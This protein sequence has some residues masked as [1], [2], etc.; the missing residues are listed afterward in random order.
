MTSQA[1]KKTN[2][3]GGGEA[4]KTACEKM[5]KGYDF[6]LAVNN[7]WTTPDSVIKVLDDLCD[8]WVFQQEEGTNG[9]VHWQGRVIFKVKRRLSTLTGKSNPFGIAHWSITGGKTFTA[10]NFNYV[11]TENKKGKVLDGPWSNKEN[12]ITVRREDKFMQN[13]VLFPWQ[14]KLVN[15][16]EVYDGRC[17]DVIYDGEGNTGKTAMIDYL[18][19]NKLASPIQPYSEIEK[20]L[21]AAIDAKNKKAFVIDMPRSMEKHKLAG[22]YAGLEGLK[23]GV[24]ADPRYK[25]REELFER[26]R[27]IVFTN[28]FPH[29]GYLSAD[30]WR[31]WYITASNKNMV[32]IDTRTAIQLN[33][34]HEGLRE[35]SAKC[36]LT[37]REEVDV[38][39]GVDNKT[40]KRAAEIRQ[41][42]SDVED[43]KW[44]L[45]EITDVIEATSMAE[46]D[47]VCGILAC[48]EDH[49]DPSIYTKV[50]RG[51]AEPG[52]P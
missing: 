14:Q 41:A 38:K 29:F 51:N 42:K 24:A 17:I 34:H 36:T 11:L 37:L 31:L 8:C 44:S 52:V 12:L 27:V 32:K 6:T 48:P 4:S 30:R 23:N 15:F 43:F 1:V 46:V 39:K 16:I 10:S 49:G 50:N 19:Y 18:R 2:N 26:P 5:V 20:V 35:A 45:K 47:T 21:S 7:R 40:V 33:K 28:D 13:A 9:Y 22:F 3:L 25:Y